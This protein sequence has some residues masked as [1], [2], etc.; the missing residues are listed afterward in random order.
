NTALHYA[1]K[2]AGS[3]AR[4][5]ELLLSNG[6]SCSRT[7]TG[8][9]QSMWPCLTIMGQPLVYCSLTPIAT[10]VMSYRKDTGMSHMDIL[11]QHSP[12]TAL[13][14]HT[15][16]LPG[17]RPD[18]P[19]SKPNRYLG[20]RT[21]VERQREDLLKHPLCA[22]TARVQMVLHS[23]LFSWCDFFFY[24][25]FLCCLTAF[26]ADQGP[27][28]ISLVDANTG[29]RNTSSSGDRYGGRGIDWGRL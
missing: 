3:S 7:T 11:I 10:G 4:S 8:R 21:M 9:H 16:F 22:R 24:A 13:V 12:Q 5:L 15:L 23:L 14:T 6:A 28:P 17:P 29:C 20:L 1:C 27:L 18:D 25:V 2:H 26:V 19:A